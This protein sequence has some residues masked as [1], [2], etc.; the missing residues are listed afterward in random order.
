[1]ILTTATAP[2]RMSVIGRDGSTA[3]SSGNP[4]AFPQTL[5]QPD[6]TYAISCH[7]RRFGIISICSIAIEIKINDAF[8]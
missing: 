7:P 5:E 2:H 1:M 6:A 4:Q 3:G 8:T